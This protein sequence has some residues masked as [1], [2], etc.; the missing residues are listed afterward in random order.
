ML[1]TYLVANAQWFTRVGFLS[2]MIIRG[3]LG[4]RDSLDGPFGS[5]LDFGCYLVPLVVLELYLRVKE[6]G[7][8]N[9]RFAMAGS[10]VVLTVLMDVA[11]FGIATFMWWPL[12]EGTLK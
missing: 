6:G 10:P 11:I 5:F 12:L 9:G 3:L 4:G 8:R 1:R 2:W 7:T